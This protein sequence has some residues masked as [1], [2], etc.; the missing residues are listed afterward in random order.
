VPPEVATLNRAKHVFVHP[1]VVIFWDFWTPYS[2]DGGELLLR[3]V[4]ILSTLLIYLFIHHF[5]VILYSTT[6]HIDE[7][8]KST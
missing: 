7:T 4:P 8:Y 5:L 1:I 3:D 2:G 6:Q